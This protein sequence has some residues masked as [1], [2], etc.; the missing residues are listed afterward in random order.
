MFD[1]PPATSTLHRFSTES[2][3]RRIIRSPSA[4]VRRSSVSASPSFSR[5]IQMQP[6][7]L[8]MTSMTS[9]IFEPMGD[10]GPECRAQHARA[11]RN[12]FRLE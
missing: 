11:A 6:S 7:G 4:G 10:R 3:Q 9:K 1:V 2:R 12:R 5:S 8:S